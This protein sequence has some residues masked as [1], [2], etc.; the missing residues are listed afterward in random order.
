M[1]EM[2]KQGRPQDQKS[3]QWQQ[4]LNPQPMAGRNDGLEGTNPEKSAPTAHDLKD[5]HARLPD[6]TNDELKQIPV[7]A[8]GS[9]L[10]QGATYINLRDPGRQE[11]TATGGMTVGEHD[12]IVP[13]TEV[14]YPLWNRLL[15]VQNP[16][17]L[18]ESSSP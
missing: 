16:E 15:G 11:F 13:K 4:D 14:A 9:R 1:A 7:L 8:P 5:L 12:W 2:Q 17:R 6:Y 3:D 10:K 18:D